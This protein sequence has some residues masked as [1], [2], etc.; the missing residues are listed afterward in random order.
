MPVE[1]QIP[2]I[3][4]GARFNGH[5]AVVESIISSST[6][7]SVYG[8]ID[9]NPA[10][11]NQSHKGKKVLGGC[12]LLPEIFHKKSVRHAIVAI[13]DNDKREEYVLKLSEIGY[14]IPNI[15][16]K[17]SIIAEDAVLG[18]G[19]VLAPGAIIMN[20][21]KMGDGVTVNTG[22]TIDHNCVLEGYD[23]ISP[24]THFSGR[25]HVEKYVFMG[26]GTI[27]IP[28]VKIGHHAYIGAGSV[29]IRD[30][31]PFEKIAG[32]PAKSISKK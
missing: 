32:V 31:P 24:G 3:I 13:G 15:I 1:K 29:V 14:E 5:A 17:S 23:N 19:C 21:V 6:N 12:D 7:F 20:G 9:D 27:L 26:T 16:H 8:Y 18:R 28:D 2:I 10:L 25:V 11:I 4:V 30:V 22:A